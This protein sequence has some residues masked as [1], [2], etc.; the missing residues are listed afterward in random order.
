MTECGPI[1]TYADWKTTRLYSCGKVVRG[2]ELKINSH[3]LGH[4]V[5]V[6]MTRGA[7]VMLGYYEIHDDTAEVWV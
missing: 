6:V 5:G 2:M 4:V 1:M 3:D 7:N